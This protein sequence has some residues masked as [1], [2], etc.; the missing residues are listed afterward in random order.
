MA[1][2]ILGLGGGGGDAPASVSPWPEKESA[3][4]PG[5]R[6][7]LRMLLDACSD[8]AESPL[9]LNGQ[10]YQ[11]QGQEGNGSSSSKEHVLGQ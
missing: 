7:V 11:H 9:A 2:F 4:A 5:G 10:H 1:F 8:G 3:I 6:Y